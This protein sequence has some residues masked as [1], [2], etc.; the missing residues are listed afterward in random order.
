VFYFPDKGEI[1]RLSEFVS[2]LC[3]EHA[4]L[5]DLNDLERR[6]NNKLREINEGRWTDSV[7]GHHIFNHLQTS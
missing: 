2:D 5:A 7:P 1:C 3:Q 6:K 4:D